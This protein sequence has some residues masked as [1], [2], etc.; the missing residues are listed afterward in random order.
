EGFVIY[1]QFTQINEADLIAQ[2]A[3]EL[4]EQSISDEHSLTILVGSNSTITTLIHLG[5]SQVYPLNA[6]FNDSLNPSIINELEQYTANLEA[7]HYIITLRNWND[8]V[9]STLAYRSASHIIL[10]SIC[11][12]FGIEERRSAENSVVLL[13][14]VEKTDENSCTQYWD[15]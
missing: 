12:R 7:G 5:R 4:A 15:R 6:E 14:V 10:D 11:E 9:L 8:L 13:E 3:T 2:S 1:N